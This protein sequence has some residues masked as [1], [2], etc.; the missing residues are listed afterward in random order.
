M[1][2]DYIKASDTSHALESLNYIGTREGVEKHDAIDAIPVFRTLSPSLSI[3]EVTSAQKKLI[4]CLK[5]NY[6]QLKDLDTF[7]EFEQDANMYSASCFIT[8][9]LSTLEE[10]A[11][12][13]EVYMKYISE[14]PGVETHTGE[15]HGLFDQLGVADYGKYK[16][17]LEKGKSHVYRDIISLTREDAIELGYDHKEQWMSLLRDKMPLKAKGLGIPLQ[18]FKWIAAFHDEG[19]HPHVHVMCWDGSGKVK[20]FQTE[21][22]ISNFKS[23]LANDIFSNEM[24]LAKEYKYEKRQELEGEFITLSQ[25]VHKRLNKGLDN[26]L[27]NRVLSEVKTLASMLPNHGSKY[28]G[29]QQED[30]KTEVNKVVDILL[31]SKQLRSIVAEYVESQSNIASFYLKSELEDYATSF[32]KSL[33]EPGPSDRKVMHN[34]ILSAAHEIKIIMKEQQLLLRKPFNGLNQKL[35]LQEV[36]SVINDEVI[37]AV[38]KVTMLQE[39][40]VEQTVHYL[41]PLVL[42]DERRLEIIL[43]NKEKHVTNKD[44][45]VL[46][47]AYSEN[48]DNNYVE[49]VH[50]SG[51]AKV[52]N[53]AN[54]MIQGVLNIFATNHAKDQQELSRINRAH[55]EDINAMKKHK[56]N[57]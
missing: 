55:K 47:K 6:R 23:V 20:T 16:D 3:K 5:N 28:Y 54:R 36:P 25:D 34:A 26:D 1:F 45:K 31:S 19:H 50:S 35:N 49:K 38:C 41:T 8:E 13:N 42:D 33:I 2:S 43:M 44:I 53:V 11:F 48:I 10:L 37:N 27:K 14:R 4:D 51:M 46:N 39:V 21:K 57:K 17:L 24:W 40:P 18:D 9:S 29:Y 7:S 56:N 52:Y 22:D 32:A 15:L 12:T 30:V